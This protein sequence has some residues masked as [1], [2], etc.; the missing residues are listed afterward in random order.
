[1][2]VPIGKLAPTAVVVAAVSCCAWP[3]V[4]SSADSGKQAAAL[5]EITAAQLSPRIMPP[6]ARDPFRPAE[7]PVALVAKPAKTAPAATTRTQSTGRPTGS[8]G[9]NGA[10]VLRSASPAG[11]KL[12]ADPLSGLALTA[13]SIVADP[14]YRVPRR[15]AIINGRIYAERERLKSK[16]PSAPSCV[17]TR[18]LPD[19]VLLECEGRTATLCYANVAAKAKANRTRSTECPGDTT[20]GSG[21]PE[22]SA[23]RTQSTGCPTGCPRPGVPGAPQP[24]GPPNPPPL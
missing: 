7:A 13:T 3:Y 8:P 11:G 6:P 4:F 17:V 22:P 5:P 12:K 16:D 1:M 20:R 19:R 9:G 23:T 2:A 24:P 14:A 10:I 18:I 15:L 21:C